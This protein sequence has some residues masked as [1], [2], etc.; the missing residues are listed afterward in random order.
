[1]LLWACAGIHIGAYNIPNNFNN[2]L[3]VQP[4]TLTILSPI[5]WAQCFHY[6]DAS[7]IWSV[8]RCCTLITAIGTMFAGIEVEL[9]FALEVTAATLFIQLSTVLRSLGVLRYYLD[10]Y[11]HAPCMEH[12]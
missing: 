7:E 6:D 12:Q 11:Q 2:A 10:I 3:L 4:Q 5:T 8:L 9:V 1:M